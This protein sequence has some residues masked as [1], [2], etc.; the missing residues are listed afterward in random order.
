MIPRAVLLS[1]A[2]SLALGARGLSAALPDW[3]TLSWGMTQ[4]ELDR[5]LGEELTELPGRWIYGGAY[6]ERAVFGFDLEGL[7]FTAYFQMNEESDRLQQILLERRG[8]VDA[9]PQAFEETLA[10]LEAHYGAAAERCITARPDGT[11]MAADLMWRLGAST[12]HASFLDFRSSGLLY[13][14]PNVD[15]DPLVPSF[16]TRRIYRRS[17]PRR[18]NIRIH[19][20]DRRDLEWPEG[21]PKLK[22]I[23][24]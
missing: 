3:P 6:A 15:L 13:F 11:I 22:R 4:G 19:P 2:L 8:G 7:S 10:M 16:E 5:A 23:D 24:P 21:C 18:I 14:D 1:L 9:T 17:L 20:S 12:V